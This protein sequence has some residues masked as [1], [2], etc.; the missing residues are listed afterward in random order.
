MP[1]KTG[2]NSQLGVPDIN[3]AVIDDTARCPVGTIIKAYDD[4]QGEGEFIYLPGVASLAKG[5]CVVYDL[6]PGAQAVVRTL[7]G[8]HLNTGRPVAFAMDAIVAGKYGWFQIGGV[9]I[10]SVL[11]A[12]AAG[13][14]VFLTTTA[15]NVDDAAVNGCQILGA[16]S[17]SA[18]ATPLAGKAYLTINRPVLQSQIT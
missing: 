7:S 8:T 12:F 10:A 18:I 1:W 9:T 14:K 16:M 4:T 15:G 11:A 6:N 2:A 13:N 5:D 17:S 3:P